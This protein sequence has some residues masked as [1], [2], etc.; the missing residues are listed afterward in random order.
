V[1]R[2]AL[3]LRFLLVAAALQPLTL[4]A[5]DPLATAKDLYASASYEAALSAL[6]AVD[7]AAGK[8]DSIQVDTYRALCFL[9]LGRTKDAESTLEQIVV[10]RPTYMIDDSEHSPRIVAMF[11]D[12]R[13]RALPAA[14][15]Q[16]YLAAKA[17]FDAKNYAAA[18]TQFKLLLGVLDAPDAGDQA[19][20]LAD[21]KELSAGFLALSEGR[22]GAEQPKQ[23]A[24]QPVP[25]TTAGPGPP[26]PA[27]AS[28][29]LSWPVAT[30]QAGARRQSMAAAAA[31]AS[32]STLSTVPTVAADVSVYSLAD[33]DVIPPVALDQRMPV[34]RLPEPLRDRALVGRLEILI[35]EAGTVQ[36]AKLAKPIWPSLDGILL[37]AAKRWRYQP[38]RRQGQPVRYRRLIEINVDSRSGG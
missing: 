18:A 28:E 5:Q 16:L 4:I 26:R 35:D 24:S 8:E 14:A 32:T 33:T 27:S 19:G 17:Q 34:W 3:L 7:S 38:A 23:A 21:I 37:E 20:K 10:R 11:R 2:G 25:V 13:R 6:T 9:A 12:V 36:E 29:P 22:L 15:Q 30:V 1:T 31:A